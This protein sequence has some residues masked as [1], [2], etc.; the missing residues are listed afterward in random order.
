MRNLNNLAWEILEIKKGSNCS[1]F[2]NGTESSKKR[3]M[4]LCH[5]TAGCL[6]LFKIPISLGK[7]HPRRPRGR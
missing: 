6:I 1:E 4:G 3:M 2:Y 7:L 5:V